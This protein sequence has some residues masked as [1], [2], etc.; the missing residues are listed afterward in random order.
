MYSDYNS[1]L[2]STAPTAPPELFQAVSIGARSAILSWELPIESGRN[3]NITSY[4]VACSD[5]DINLIVNDEVSDTS[6][7]V[8]G[9]QPYSQYNCTVTAS[10]SAGEGPPAQLTFNTMEDSM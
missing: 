3:G 8:E 9:L 6:F 4:S 10:T 2:I 7:T 5:A 1:Y